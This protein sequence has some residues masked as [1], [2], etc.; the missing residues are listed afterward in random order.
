MCSPGTGVT[1]LSQGSTRVQ[2]GPVLFATFDEVLRD[3][4]TVERST[5]FYKNDE[6]FDV[7]VK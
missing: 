5:V 7:T 3:N 1:E 2:P 4:P 6:E